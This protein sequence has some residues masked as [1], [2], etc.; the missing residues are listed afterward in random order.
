MWIKMKRKKPQLITPDLLIEL[1]AFA[2]VT[3]QKMADFAGV[4]IET[5]SRWKRGV[6]GAPDWEQYVSLCLGVFKGKIR[7]DFIAKQITKTARKL[8]GSVEEKT[9]Y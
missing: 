8:G 9:D 6:G 5:Y 4:R 3:D 7:L 2:Q 1:Q